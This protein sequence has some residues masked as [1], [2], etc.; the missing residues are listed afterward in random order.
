MYGCGDRL[1]DASVGTVDLA[2]FVSVAMRGCMVPTRPA[3]AAVVR[4]CVRALSKVWSFSVMS[5]RP[6][7]GRLNRVPA[8]CAAWVPR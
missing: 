6:E 7:D 3:S 2:G 1:L 4:T 5:V 8:V